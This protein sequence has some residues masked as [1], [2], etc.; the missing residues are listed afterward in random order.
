MISFSEARDRVVASINPLTATELQP[1]NYA[2]G[3]V[4]AEPLIAPFDIPRQ[5]NSAMDGFGVRFEDI[6]PDTEVILP[7]SAEIPTGI[8]PSTS[9]TPKTAVRIMTGAVTPPGCDVVI[10]QEDVIRDADGIRIPPGQ[11]LQ[12]NIR[13]AG[14]DMRQGTQIISRGRRL[15]PADLGI[16]AAFGY[17]KVNVIRRLRVALL[18]TGNEITALDQ[19]LAPGKIYDSNR[20]ILTGLLIALGIEVIDLGIARDSREEIS[21]ALENGARA[22]AVIT[23]GG[24]SVGDFDLVRNVLSERGTIAF[25][26]VAMKPGKPQAYGYLGDTPFFGLPGNPVSSFVVFQLIVR[27]ALLRLMGALPEIDRHLRLPL[28]GGAIRKKH[29]RMD[30][31]RAIIHFDPNGA[32][33]ESAG[34]QGSGMLNSLSRANALIILPPHPIEIPEGDLVD[35]WEINY[36]V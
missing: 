30:F 33:V 27:P 12:Q 19:Q 10:P 25:W 21:A 35:V 13:L 29:H 11:K 22:D 18:S 36:S 1:V 34:E 24:V 17:S 9:I 4:L 8:C 28:R 3:R 2:F 14:E 26:Q 7:V 23:S 31:M 15:T 16:L 20:A 5:H 6:S 32:W